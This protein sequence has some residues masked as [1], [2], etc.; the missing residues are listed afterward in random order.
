M[1]EY[2]IYKQWSDLNASENNWIG[3]L[4]LLVLWGVA[5][6]IWGAEF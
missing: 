1:I 6:E 5:S 3:A 4:F 2:F